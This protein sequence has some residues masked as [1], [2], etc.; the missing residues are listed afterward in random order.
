MAVDIGG[1]MFKAYLNVS[2]ED[3]IGSF[4]QER[5]LYTLLKAMITFDQVYLMNKTFRLLLNI[6]RTIYSQ[7]VSFGFLTKPLSERVTYLIAWI[8]EESLMLNYILCW[9]CC[10]KFSH[11]C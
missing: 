4:N 7:F 8:Y 10:R 9:K 5:K 6:D 1:K 11:P 3:G 2:N